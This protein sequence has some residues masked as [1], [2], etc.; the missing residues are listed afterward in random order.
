MAST[1]IFLRLIMLRSLLY[2][3]Q[4][5]DCSYPFGSTLG[6]PVEYPMVFVIVADFEE[7]SRGDS[8]INKIAARC[9]Q[10]G[11][12]FYR[13]R[14]SFPVLAIFIEWPEAVPRECFRWL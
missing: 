9:L 3:F 13:T 1:V 6:R 5:Y 12:T 8:Y 7:T 4:V 2:R 14:G 11:L 10:K